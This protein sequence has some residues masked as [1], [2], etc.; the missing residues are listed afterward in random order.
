MNQSIIPDIS[1]IKSFYINLKKDKD[2]NNNFVENDVI[3]FQRFPAI[4]GK[5]YKD[6][7]LFMDKISLLTQLKIHFNRRNT[8][9]EINSFGAIGCSLSHYYLWKSFMDEKLDEEYLK[10]FKED[11]ENNIK[12]LENISFS[13]KDITKNSVEDEYLLVFE[14]D[15]Y[16][17]DISK[18]KTQIE[19]DIRELI[20]YKIDWDIC[21]IKHALSRD[22]TDLSELRLPSFSPA[23]YKSILDNNNKCNNKYCKI[24][25][26]FGTQNYIIKRSAIKKI[27]E[28]NYF[29]PI[30]CH[31][32]TFLGLLAQ[33]NI[34][35]I[36]A[37]D[38]K[39]IGISIYDTY[40]TTIHHSIPLIEY[41]LIYS[42]IICILICV[43][44]YLLT[45]PFLL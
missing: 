1:K 16:F 39:N 42:I 19:N 37:S 5:K 4:Y 11:N 6:N 31:I 2:R 15:V 12:D 26:F 13:K 24:N 17:T 22:A 45:R 40:Y 34:L 10:F 8:H 20:K 7:K 33:K 3:K 32:D 44:I 27:I 30:E 28:S 14:D 29:F 21:L 35:K 38:N 9:G 18:F 41:N 43:I 36:V 23:L 25:A